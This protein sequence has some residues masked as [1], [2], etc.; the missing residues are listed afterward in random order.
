MDAFNFIRLLEDTLYHDAGCC[1]DLNALREL[2]GLLR[3]PACMHCANYAG[4]CAGLHAPHELCGLLSGATC[5]VHYAPRMQS[6]SAMTYSFLSFA[7]CVIIP[8][9][10]VL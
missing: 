6:S 8:H 2:R 5:T 9:H 4:C 10:A 3:W 1:A 7:I